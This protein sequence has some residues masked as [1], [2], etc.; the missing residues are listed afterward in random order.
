[1]RQQFKRTGLWLVILLL[2]TGGVSARDLLQ[3]DQCFVEADQVIGGNL[4][5]VCRILTIDGHVEGNVIGV[6]T[7]AIISSSATIDGD[8]YLLAGQLDVHGTVGHGVHFAGAVL[9]MHET[10]RFVDEHSNLISLSLSTRLFE[11]M[12]FPG[13]IVNWGYQLILDGQVGD[14]VNFW[15]SALHIGGQVTDDV[16]ASV[17]DPQSTGVSQ[18][19]TLFIPFALDVELVNPG[20]IM[21][22]NARITGDLVYTGVSV[23]DIEGT[24]E[25]EIDYTPASLGPVQIETGSLSL[26]LA[27]VV[28]EF[29][30]LAIIGL[31][32][33]FFAPRA[34]HKPLHHLQTRPISSTSVGLLSFILS[35]PVI[36]MVFVLSLLV[37]GI[38]SLLR[39]DG[40]FIPTL[41][42]LGFVNVGGTALF[43]FIA[44]FVARVIVCIVLGR[45]ML[46]MTIGD[47]DSPRLLYMGMVVGVLVLSLLAS[48]P[49]IGWV[50]NAVALFLGLGTLLSVFLNQLQTFRQQ[51]QTAPPARYPRYV[52]E[53]P[54]L[55]DHPEEARRIPPPIIDSSP[56]PPGADNLP[57]GFDWWGNT[58]DDN[59]DS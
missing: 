37:L 52:P 50:V 14:E 27:Q 29:T 30:T 19:E 12:V 53:R 47:G 4:F 6:A 20:L 41:V 51:A 5:V 36:M 57:E 7:T 21:G 31:F 45:W 26:Y 42:V 15:G 46:R 34:I 35:F 49:V 11:D 56:S 2:I 33:L 39:L 40:V 32:L 18:I 3:G 23:G 22:E 44:I 16:F 54:P 28:R 58:D 24:V 8:L 43:Y 38:L 17:G 1:M 59:P 13:T 10:T 55:P 25:G 48:L 9:R